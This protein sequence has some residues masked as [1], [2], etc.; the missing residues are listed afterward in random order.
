MFGLGLPWQI[1]D[2]CLWPE[3]NAFLSC[4]CCSWLCRLPSDRE[5]VGIVRH[6]MHFSSC[7][8]LFLLASA[9]DDGEE[10]GSSE[11]AM[12]R[13]EEGG[14]LGAGGGE[15]TP[16]KKSQKGRQGGEREKRKKRRTTRRA[17]SSEGRSMPFFLALAR[18]HQWSMPCLPVLHDCL[19]REA[20]SLVLAL[21]CCSCALAGGNR[22]TGIFSGRIVLNLYGG[23]LLL[24]FACC[25]L[26]P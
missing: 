8:V 16:G 4:S 23:L 14:E 7:F 6:V 22:Q 9:D 20:V 3:P 2:Q 24:L 17:H 13:P 12:S 21:A 18:S 19:Q 5:H 25:C 26:Q 15:S 10:E 1:A 11:S